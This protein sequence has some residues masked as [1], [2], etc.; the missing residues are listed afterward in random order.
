MIKRAITIICCSILIMQSGGALSETSGVDCSAVKIS[1]TGPLDF[2]TLRFEKRTTGHAVMN[3][4]G[5]ME[6]YNGISTASGAQNSLGTISISGPSNTDIYV[7]LVEIA[8]SN[9]TAPA[10][11]INLKLNKTNLE[12][13]R[14]GDLWVVR[15]PR[16]ENKLSLTTL[17]MSGTLVLNKGLEHRQIFSS[18]VNINCEFVRKPSD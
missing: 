16:S 17:S 5:R 7:S 3:E 13:P 14:A 8:Q 11:L 4:R 18:A 10:R 6:A 1:A 9:R 15:T 12:L 2:G